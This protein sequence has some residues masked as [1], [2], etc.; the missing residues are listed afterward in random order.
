MQRIRVTAMRM[1]CW[2]CSNTRLDKIRNKVIRGKIEVASR[3]NKIKE[4][5]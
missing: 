2:M 4:A 5:R 3:E 1:I